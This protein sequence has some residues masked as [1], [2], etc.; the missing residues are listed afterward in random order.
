MLGRQHALS[1][2]LVGVGMTAAIP[3]APIPVQALVVVITGGAGLLPDLDHPAATA[4]RSLGWVTRFLALGVDRMSLAIYHASRTPGD[5]ADRHSG[6]RLVTHTAPGALFLG[7]LA[8][9]AAWVSPVAAVVTCALLAGLLSL[10]LRVAGIGLALAGGG[11]AWVVV[12]QYPGW[13]WLVPVA[14]T[15][16]CLAHVAGDWVTNS[17]VPILWPLVSDGKRWRLVHAPVTFAA[18]DSVETLLVAPALLVSLV[19]AT[20]TVTGVLP[21]VVSAVVASGSS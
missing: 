7:A 14:V 15:V 8:G 9:A 6:H 10:G 18:G 12:S 21:A 17:G 2:L 19:L 11:L 4:A 3:G 1:A 20:A 5:V 16:G 13:S